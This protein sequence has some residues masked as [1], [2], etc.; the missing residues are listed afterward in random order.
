MT[1]QT[2]T[3][4][5]TPISERVIHLITQY[6]A[7]AAKSAEN[8]L[9]LARVMREAKETLSKQEFNDFCQGIGMDRSASTHK[10]LQVIAKQLPALEAHKEKLPSNWTTLYKVATL[11]AEQLQAVVEQGV[12]KPNVTGHAIN[13]A[14]SI[15]PKCKKASLGRHKVEFKGINPFNSAP[16]YQALRDLAVKMSVELVLDEAIASVLREQDVVPN[17]TIKPENTLDRFL[18]EAA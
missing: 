10:K 18:F 4:T 13:R 12:L 17:G 14:L 3:Q 16:F 15:Q 7:F 5:Q 9:E 11:S 1:I 6:K 8:V 2:Q